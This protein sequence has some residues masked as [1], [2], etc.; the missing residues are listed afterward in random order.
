MKRLALALLTLSLGACA[1]GGIAT[2]GNKVIIT[3]NDLFLFG[4][5]RSIYVCDVTPEGDVANCKETVS[6]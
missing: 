5:L 6:P 3:R 1:Y 2:A 4:A